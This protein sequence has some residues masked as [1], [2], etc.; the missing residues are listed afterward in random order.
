MLVLATEANAGD[1]AGGVEYAGHLLSYFEA[2]VDPTLLLSMAASLESKATSAWELGV[3][4]GLRIEA[5]EE[6]DRR[7][8]AVARECE[9]S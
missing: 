7:A 3:A 9:S 5:T 6:L 8:E 1:F 4:R 2:P